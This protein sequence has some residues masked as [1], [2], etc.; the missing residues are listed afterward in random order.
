MSIP[1][2]LPTPL[3]IEQILAQEPEYSTRI[4]RISQ[5]IVTFLHMTKNVDG[6]KSVL[7]IKEDPFDQVLVLRFM[8]HLYHDIFSI[9]RR[10]VEKT[11]G[12]T[13]FHLVK[14]GDRSVQ[15]ILVE[16]VSKVIL[17]YERQVFFAPVS[18]R[19][20]RKKGE[21]GPA[22]YS[23]G[24][25]RTGKNLIY[26]VKSQTD[27]LIPTVSHICRKFNG[28]ASQFVTAAN[29]NKP[30]RE[31]YEDIWGIFQAEQKV[32]EH[33]KELGVL[34][35]NKLPFVEK[36]I[37]E[38]DHL[39]LSYQEKIES[40]DFLEEKYQKDIEGLGQSNE[41]LHKKREF[42]NKIRTYTSRK[43]TLRYGCEKSHD[44]AKYLSTL[45]NL[46]EKFPKIERGIE[47][48]I[49]SNY[50]ARSVQR[51]LEE[52]N[53]EIR[54]IFGQQK[55]EAFKIISA[56][57][58]KLKGTSILYDSAN[59]YLAA[60]KMEEDMIRFH[61][62]QV[63]VGNTSKKGLSNGQA[64]LLSNVKKIHKY[65]VRLKDANDHIH[66][67]LISYRS[68]VNGYTENTE[69]GEKD[70]NDKDLGI[71][72]QK[73]L[74]MIEL[75]FKKEILPL[76]KECQMI[77]QKFSEES[78]EEKHIGEQ[79][80]R[81]FMS[82]TKRKLSSAMKKQDVVNFQR[83]KLYQKMKPDGDVQSYYIKALKYFMKG[84]A[85]DLLLPKSIEAAFPEQLKSYKASLE[86]RAVQKKDQSQTG[87]I[88]SFIAENISPK[89]VEDFSRFVPCMP[90]NELRLT[91]PPGKYFLDIAEKHLDYITSEAKKQFVLLNPGQEKKFDNEVNYREL[92]ALEI[93]KKAYKTIR[94]YMESHFET[95]EEEKFKEFDFIRREKIKW[96]KELEQIIH[97]LQ[98]HIDILKQ[99][100]I[101]EEGSFRK[102]DEE[103]M[104]LMMKHLSSDQIDQ[105]EKQ[106]SREHKLDKDSELFE[107]EYMLSQVVQ[108]FLDKLEGD[109]IL[110]EK[111]E[112]EQENKRKMHLGGVMD[113]IQKKTAELEKLKW[114]ITI[115]E[116]IFKWEFSINP[117]LPQS[118]KKLVKRVSLAEPTSSE[119]K[120]MVRYITPI[121]LHRIKENIGL[122]RKNTDDEKFVE[123]METGLSLLKIC[124]RCFEIAEK[125]DEKLSPF[126]QS[127]LSSVLILR[128]DTSFKFDLENFFFKSNSKKR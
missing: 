30:D 58:F 45:K 85:S 73:A 115:D 47:N 78:I 1:F 50:Q 127:C 33:I 83:F 29:R 17:N 68:F 14:V 25:K 49:E 13:P 104:G 10:L 41:E 76:Y 39:K 38:F 66:V 98:Y 99:E 40:L 109:Y 55:I 128:E 80:I 59:Y 60:T 15:D 93:V 95:I 70:K 97:R 71:R 81:A 116:Y 87:I 106:F 9:H 103:E 121:Q 88:F 18:A 20:D 102:F 69:K 100:A 72:L 21:Y 16:A 65:M 118:Q 7:R 79:V 84:E 23:E 107:I 119:F 2:N 105:L 126:E 111:F 51:F 19:L 11:G 82:L 122:I 117:I 110:K 94:S 101:K 44:I 52:I 53:G 5:F 125:D 34:E 6:V 43:V 35:K 54:D 89:E 86:K 75:L 31:K 62:D 113:E 24:V 64:K 28:I 96:Q 120:K 112:E 114:Q 67:A 108:G 22:M 8:T 123:I 92:S 46:I 32:K 48:F 37:E 12:D 61:S 3:Q 77:F 74:R 90:S 26:K 63:S 4:E 27:E 124:Q 42:E 57:T 56:L 36:L 91:I